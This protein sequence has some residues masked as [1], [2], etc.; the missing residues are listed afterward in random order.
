[1]PSTGNPTPAKKN[2]AIAGMADVPA[3]TPRS[4]GKM[5]FPAPKN[6]EKSVAPTTKLSRAPRLLLSVE[7]SC[8][9]RISNTTSYNPPPPS[10]AIAKI[11][12]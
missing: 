3:C 2:P 5:R 11:G 6:I 12:P 4:G 9:S 1:M 10:S 7:M 8:L